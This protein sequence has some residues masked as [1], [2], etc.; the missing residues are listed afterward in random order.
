MIYFVE[1]RIKNTDKKNVELLAWLIDFKDRPYVL[2]KR[3]NREN[4]F[5]IEENPQVDIDDSCN[6]ENEPKPSPVPEAS[7]SSTFTQGQNESMSSK[8]PRSKKKILVIALIVALFAIMGYLNLNRTMT[9]SKTS[10]N[11]SCMYWKDDHYERISCGQKLQYSK[12]IALDMDLLNNF[13]KITIPDTITY[14]SIGKVWY[15]KIKGNPEFYTAMGYHPIFMQLQLKPISEYIIDNH[16]RKNELVNDSLGNLF[17]V[18]NT[19]DNIKQVKTQSWGIYG[20]C[21]AITKAKNRCSRSA[22]S[23]GFCW[24]HSKQKA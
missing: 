20:Q 17:P 5:A 9:L 19:A 14:N 11:D 7:A 3:Y 21:K 12:V 4:R 24:Q 18:T 10:N 16:I 23:G 22:K 2:N 15:I 6:L 1:G 8:K 13:R